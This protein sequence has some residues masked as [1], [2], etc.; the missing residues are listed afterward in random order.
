ML[1]K[2]LRA[3]KVKRSWHIY[4][5]NLERGTASDDICDYLKGNG[6]D[7]ILCEPL[8]DGHWD[9]R[10]ASFHIEIDYDKKDKDESF[11]NVVVKIRNWF[12]PK[13]K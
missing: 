11:W 9:E 12:F 4:I 5:G 10:P 8:G 13:K 1:G 2:A 6:V 3:A 7:V